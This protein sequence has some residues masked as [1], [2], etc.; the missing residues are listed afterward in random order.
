MDGVII[1][2]GTGLNESERWELP[3]TAFL[4]IKV[5]FYNCRLTLSQGSQSSNIMHPA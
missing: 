3:V 5:N 4:A 1:D 2:C